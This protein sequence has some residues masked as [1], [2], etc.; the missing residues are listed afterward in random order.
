MAYFIV[1]I[2]LNCSQIREESCHAQKYTG[3]N[4]PRPTGDEARLSEAEEIPALVFPSPSNMGGSGLAKL[5]P[6]V[7]SYLSALHAHP[8]LG[9]GGK[10]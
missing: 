5:I 9:A 7:A 4:V 2:M 8:L 6:R 1:S 3:V 10:W